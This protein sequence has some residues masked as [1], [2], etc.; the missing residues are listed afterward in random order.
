MRWGK[1][2][3]SESRVT[4][5]RELKQGRNQSLDTVVIIVLTIVKFVKYKST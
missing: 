3:E 1:S 2:E 5:A 4:D